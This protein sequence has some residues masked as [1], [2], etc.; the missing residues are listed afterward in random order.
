M[1]DLSQAGKKEGRTLTSKE[2]VASLVARTVAADL[3]DA[4]VEMPVAVLLRTGNIHENTAAPT[5]LGHK[6][7]R[8]LPRRILTSLA[9]GYGLK[10]HGALITGPL[11]DVE[12]G[13]ILMGRAQQVVI[14]TDFIH[15]RLRE[16]HPPLT[17]PTEEPCMQ[18]TIVQGHRI[19]RSALR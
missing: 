19:T 1:P 9:A 8:S 18:T 13:S 3:A 16:G 6:A 11:N 2:R 10:R 5:F 14:A 12:Q 15:G 7:S 4:V 17:S